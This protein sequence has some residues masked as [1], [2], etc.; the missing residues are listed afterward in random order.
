MHSHL[1]FKSIITWG[2]CQAF[3]LNAQLSFP[4]KPSDKGKEIVRFLPL[5]CTAI[6]PSKSFPTWG[7]SQSLHLLKHSYPSQQILP[8]MGK[9]LSFLPLKLRLILFLMGKESSFLPQKCKVNLPHTGKES[10]FLPRM[11]NVHPPPKLSFSPKCNAT[12]P[13]RGK[14]SSPFKM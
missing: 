5:K 14:D 6:F 8:H 11:L 9:D 7:R 3:F 2:R 1:P 13:H 12:L 10:C 4:T